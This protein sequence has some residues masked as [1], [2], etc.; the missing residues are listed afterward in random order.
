MAG[1]EDLMSRRSELMNRIGGSYKY[2]ANF[3]YTLDTH[4][5]SEG[6]DN[7]QDEFLRR[8]KEIYR[9]VSHSRA[10]ENQ[11]GRL[12]TRELEEYA[13]Y[14]ESFIDKAQNY[15]AVRPL[16]PSI[17]S[18]FSDTTWYIG[19]ASEG[20]RF[21]DLYRNRGAHLRDTF[22]SLT[23]SEQLMYLMYEVE[24]D[25]KL[26]GTAKGERAT[27]LRG[28]RDIMKIEELFNF[29]LSSYAFM[30]ETLRDFLNI[31][32]NGTENY[33]WSDMAKNGWTRIVSFGAKMHQVTAPNSQI[34]YDMGYSEHG[35]PQV[36][37]VYNRLNEKFMHRDGREAVFK[38]GGSPDR[39]IIITEY[40]DKGTYNYFVS[41]H[42]IIHGAESLQGGKHNRWDMEPY[43][44]LM[45]S[46]KRTNAEFRELYIDLPNG[47]EKDNMFNFNSYYWQF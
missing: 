13:G 3:I 2:M 43:I 39:G 8:L 38:Y 17:R 36:I 7:Y 30:N 5:R 4:K 45:E 14:I 41:E 20:S 27:Y 19:P 46:M 18:E 15:R 6:I 9:Y 31:G 35:R 29:N 40:P 37:Q 21:V 10:Y 12:S 23:V 24:E 1:A 32:E 34:Y 28:L 25:N 42:L 47:G 33:Q 11:I 26:I 44:I 22:Q 16:N